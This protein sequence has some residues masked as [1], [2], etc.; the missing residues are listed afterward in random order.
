MYGLVVNYRGGE[1][2]AEQEYVDRLVNIM[3]L[4]DRGM[5]TNCDLRLCIESVLDDHAER[6]VLLL[7]VSAA[8][9]TVK[10]L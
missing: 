7:A 6:V 2:V 5:L 1:T 4:V 8:K 9:E 3:E 10:N